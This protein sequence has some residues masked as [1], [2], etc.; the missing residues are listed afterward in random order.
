MSR[1]DASNY[2]A[3]EGLAAAGVMAGGAM[4]VLGTAGL[5]FFDGQ[6]SSFWVTVG[7]L[8]VGWV[9]TIAL[10]AWRV[11]GPGNWTGARAENGE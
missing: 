3:A 5:L 10:V 4:A 1:L 8:F 6:F 7:G 11:W 2:S 9:S